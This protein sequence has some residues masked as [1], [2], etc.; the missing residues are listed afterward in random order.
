MFGRPADTGRL[1]DWLAL[2]EAGRPL[3]SLHPGYSAATR[4]SPV[5]TPDFV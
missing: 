5:L 1:S 3:R 4:T 2:R